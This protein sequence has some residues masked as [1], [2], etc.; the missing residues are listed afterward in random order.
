MLHSQVNLLH[1]R[2]L[3]VALIVVMGLGAA[4][5]WYRRRLLYP[6]L[7]GS[8]GLKP[9]QVL[10]RARVIAHRGSRNEGLPENSLPAFLDALRKG[11]D[12]IECDV[13][14]TADKEV[15]VHHDENLKRVTGVDKIIHQVDYKTLPELDASKPGQFERLKDFENDPALSKPLLRIPKLSEVIALLPPHQGINIEFKQ[16]EWDL[17]KAVHRIILDSGKKHQVFWFSLDEKINCKLRQ[18]DP[19]I[20]TVVSI[21]GSLKTLGL[22][23]LGMLP[24]MEM[25]DA[26][27]GITIEEVTLEKVREE[28][29]L[30]KAPDLVKRFLAWLLQGRPPKIMLQPMLFTHLRRRG[31]QT[32]FMTV[33]TEEDLRIALE[34]GATGVL[35]DRPGFIVDLLHRNN[36]RFKFLKE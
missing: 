17:V 26:V 10:P 3:I 24:F 2:M 12:V 7:G 18:M 6:I 22:Y 33:N 11:A 20:P 15:V 27:Y 21:T 34:A 14:L 23:H 9:G 29:A 19:T 25:Q 36:W 31:I 5:A 4:F 13:W 30:Q 28:E 16:D 1:S 8:K 35:T 32:W